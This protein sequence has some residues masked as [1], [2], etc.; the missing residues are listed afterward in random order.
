MNIDP[1]ALIL[2]ADLLFEQVRD[3]DKVEPFTATGIN[4]QQFGADHGAAEVGGYQTTDDAG[5]QNVFTNPLQSFR[6]RGKVG[7][8]HIAAGDAVFNHFGVADIGG[9]QGADLG[10]ID[11]GDEENVIRCQLKGFEKVGG[12][13]I[14]L[15]DHQGDHHP[16]SATEFLTMLDVGLHVL[17]FKGEQLGKAG[18]NAQIGEGVP[19][20]QGN[21]EE[22]TQEQGALAEN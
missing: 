3:V 13:D 18:I 7:R 16:V 5:F 14:P 12:K 22:N 11:A 1:V 9:E 6:R 21:D 4:F 8:N 19:H 2:V 10:A 17:M 15:F 20:Q